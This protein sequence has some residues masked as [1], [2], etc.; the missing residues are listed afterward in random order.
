M[1][2]QRYNI[3]LF[4][5]SVW[6]PWPNPH[7]LSERP[8]RERIRAI[9]PSSATHLDSS[10][11]NPQIVYEKML[12]HVG[13]AKLRYVRGESEQT[14]SRE[15][16]KRIISVKITTA[17]PRSAPHTNR[18][19]GY[20]ASYSSNR[21]SSDWL[22]GGFVE[23]ICRISYVPPQSIDGTRRSGGPERSPF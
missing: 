6:T 23:S 11:N 1:T 14:Q 3:A 15:A 13:M 12:A 8:L 2:F 10:F 21:E 16:R 18:S 7:S 19:K 22:R 4:A 20:L 17:N 9:S 5:R